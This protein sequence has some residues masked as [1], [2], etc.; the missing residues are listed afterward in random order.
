MT[1]PSDKLIQDTGHWPYLTSEYAPIEMTIKSFYEDF[2]VREIA[3]YEPDGE[4]DHTYFDIEKKGITTHE[5]V[6]RI[7]KALSVSRSHVGF[8]GLKDAHGVTC[9]R[10]SLEHIEPDLVRGLEWDDLKVISVTKHRNKIKTGH[11]KGNEFQLK[12]RDIPAERIGDLG[13]ICEILNRRGVPNYF[14]LQRFGMRGDTWLV[15]KALIEGEWREAAHWIAGSPQPF[16]YGPAREARELFDRGEYKKALDTWPGG[17]AFASKICGA[18]VRNGGHFRKAIFSI[19]KKMLRFFV[20]AYQ[21]Y[22]FNAVLAERITHIDAVMQ[23]DRA[24]KHE[25]HGQFT[26]EDV[27]T[28]NQRAAVF[29][30]SATGPLYGKKMNKTEGAAL[31]VE[32]KVLERLNADPAVFAKPGALV[33]LGSRRPLRFLPQNLSLSPG[34]DEHGNYMELKV[35]LP[36]GCYVTMLL[37][38]LAKTKLMDAGRMNP[39]G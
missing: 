39:A 13:K 4:G 37:R 10:L 34:K 7:A 12:L 27:N 25:T 3:A 8:A 19:D 18:L 32:N 28:D 21:S 38:E 26:V 16:D 14:G 29:E 2:A 5:A 1:F 20:S 24:Y 11:L 36:A 17:H 31:E 9:Q 33:C 35:T 15:G 23:G 22:L 6:A 30:I